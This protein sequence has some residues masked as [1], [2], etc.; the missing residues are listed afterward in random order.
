VRD[1]ELDG[2]WWLPS[3]P[4]RKVA[5]TVSFT[6]ESRPTL[7]LIGAFTQAEERSPGSHEISVPEEHAVI[8]GLCG[9]G[10]VTLVDCGLGGL[11]GRLG[12]SEQ[13]RQSLQ[14]RLMLVGIWLDQ[15]DEAYFDQ[16]VVGVDHLL[17]WSEHSGMAD[18]HYFT[19]E[20]LTGSGHRWDHKEPLVAQLGEISVRIA[21]GSSTGGK[22]WADRNERTINESAGFVVDVPEPCSADALIDEWTKPSKIC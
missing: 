20:R 11:E 13:W 2:L 8:H 7:R 6:G 21:L 10:S 18:D 15:P 1:V 14:A 12:P 17:A 16:V 22:S 4:D 19:D 5:G 9:Q 3:E